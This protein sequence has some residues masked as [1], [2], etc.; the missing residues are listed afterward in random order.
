MENGIKVVHILEGFLGGTSTYMTTVL[1]ELVG[2]G[3]DVTLV[4]SVNRCC[5]DASEK[6]SG[7]RASGVKVHIVPMYRKISPFK[8]VYSFA[9]VLRLLSKDRY[10][11][12]HTHCSKAG[13]LGR[14]AA[15]LAGKKVR[16]HTP[17]CFAFT[18]CS[19]RFKRSFYLMLEKLLG[20]FTTGLITV[21]SSE[22]EA[23]IC[24]RIVPGHKCTRISNA[25]SNGQPRSKTVSS[26]KKSEAKVALGLGGDTRVVTTAC[27]LVEYKGIFRYLEAAK[28]SQTPNT[29]FVVAGDGELEAPAKRYISENGLDGKVKLLGHISNMEQIYAVSDVVVLCSDAEAQPYL[30]LE[31]MRAECPI[32]ATSVIGNKE[33]ISHNKTG[34]LTAPTAEGVAVAVDRLLSDT[35]KSNQYAQNAYAY[36]YDHHR[37]D[38]QISELTDMYK[39]FK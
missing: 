6:I 15:F 30:L 35:D 12:V 22:A 36:F 7:L 29:V 1:P 5:P 20:R 26:R 23:A 19:G 25:L 21:S 10:D 32:A 11:I 38:K 33:L 3:F 14:I 28:L 34:L 18:R 17:H 4:C 8:D 27:R 24:S 37:L 13:A 39:S 9:R 16:L 31:A 2:R